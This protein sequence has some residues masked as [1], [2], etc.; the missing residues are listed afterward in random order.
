MSKLVLRFKQEG[1]RKISIN[2]M[3][4][5]Y[6]LIEH[7]FEKSEVAARVKA[8]LTLQI[9]K[10]VK[11]LRSISNADL[12]HWCKKKDRMRLADFE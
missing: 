8:T 4:L 12:F 1:G 11:K 2:F 7:C 6:F 10:E 9:I 5:F 3:Q